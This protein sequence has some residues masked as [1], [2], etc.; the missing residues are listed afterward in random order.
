MRIA[1]LGAAALVLLATSARAQS[2]AACTPT[3]TVPSA[4]TPQ[5]AIVSAATPVNITITPSTATLGG[6]TFKRNLYQVAGVPAAYAPPTLR[7]FPGGSLNLSVNNSMSTDPTKADTIY[8][9]TVTNFHFHGFNVTPGRGGGSANKGD[10]VV[11]VSYSAGTTHPYQFTLPA[12]H[13]MGMHWYHPHPHGYTDEQVGGGMSGAFLVGDIRVTRLPQNPA[14]PERVLLVKDFQPFGANGSGSFFTI[15]GGWPA[16]FNVAA[17]TAELWHVGNVGSDTYAGVALLDSAAAAQ[18]GKI[19]G[20]RVDSAYVAAALAGTGATVF[21][22]IVIGMDGNG[23]VKAD[24]VGSLELSPAIRYSAVVQTPNQPGRTLLVVNSVSSF[25]VNGFGSILGLVRLTGSGKT[26]APITIAADP[27]AKSKIT[28]LQNA[29]VSSPQTFTFSTD[30]ALLVNDISIAFQINGQPYDHTRIDA[31]VEQ[32]TTADWTLI[33]ADTAAFVNSPHVFHIHQG[34]FLVRSLNGTALPANVLQ[35][36]LSIAPGDT[37][38]VRIPFTEGFQTGIY[39]FHCHILFHEDHGMMKNV[40]V[41]PSDP[42]Q[43]GGQTGKQ[44]CDSQIASAG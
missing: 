23:L 6:C 14:M 9:S 28:A 25:A 31:Y 37:M 20:G 16:A 11:T 29:T 32:G 2:T 21:P 27:T 15:N 40:C 8:H 30:S 43:R 22:F 44:W 13:P 42:S 17:G 4:A 24:T 38:V 18:A 1:S 10:Q 35:D 36:R 5:P 33:N 12:T 41:Y 3:Y 39:V 19:S 26:P 7:L 34:D